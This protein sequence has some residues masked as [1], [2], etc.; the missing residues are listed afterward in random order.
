[1]KTL[2]RDIEDLED[3]IVVTRGYLLKSLKKILDNSLRK[4]LTKQTPT[5]QKPKWARIV[6]QAASVA[7]SILKDTELE[8]LSARL[9]TLEQKG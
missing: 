4:V 3:N 9:E 1:M 2:L 6:I 7:G 5:N 8:D